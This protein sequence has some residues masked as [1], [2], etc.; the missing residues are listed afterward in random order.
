[1]SENI[2]I[3]AI[4]GATASGKS[5]L[6]EA[7]A[8]R[9]GGEIV[10]AD[11]MQIYRGMDIGTAKPTLEERGRVPYHLIDIAD[12]TADFSVADYI[13]AAD[14]AIA[15]IAA[16]GKLPILCGGTGLYLDALLR[17]LPE[18]PAADP[19]LRAELAARAE[20][21]G[22]QAL[23]RALAAVDPQSAAVTPPGNLRRVIRAL[24]IY[25]SSGITKTEWDKKS[26]ENPPRYAA[27]VIGMTYRDRELL[28]RRIEQRVDLMLAAG[29][30]EETARLE[31][32]GVFRLSRTAAG[33]IGYKEI[34]PYLRGESDLSS[35]V[36]TLK[37]ATRRYAKRQ[38]TWFSAKDYVRPLYA[39]DGE[40]NLRNFE[41]IVN[42]ALAM[43]KGTNDML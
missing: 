16:R 6:A 34:L 14:A 8:L 17:G 30:V 41:E 31:E 20:R 37:T 33:A 22:A 42:N 40:G 1:M 12:A 15:D 23:H 21:E 19:S 24:E 43:C 18:S 2:K 27:N 9:L 32:A 5:A 13:V 11:S 29:L 35:A 39:D 4:V 36:Q 38:I 25:I 28:Y 7:L 10:S 3:L 26:L